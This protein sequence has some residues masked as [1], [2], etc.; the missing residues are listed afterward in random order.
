MQFNFRIPATQAVHVETGIKFQ[1]DYPVQE[2][3]VKLSIVEGQ[4]GEV[5]A[6]KA[7][8]LLGELRLEVDNELRR[9]EFSDLVMS[10]WKN[11]V[12]EVT[13]VL[14]KDKTRKVST[15]TVQSWL[16]DPSKSSSRTCPAWAVEALKNYLA[17]NPETGEIMERRLS[18]ALEHDDMMS[19]RAKRDAANESNR[20][21]ESELARKKLIQERLANCSISNLPRQLTEEIWALRE[22][23]ELQDMMIQA[24]ISTVKKSRNDDLEKNLDLFL[25]AGF[26]TNRATRQSME[27]IENGEL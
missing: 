5:T 11:D 25:R 8:A 15:R 12:L 9:R 6:D 26:E 7:N 21:A 19:V 20:W 10:G 16:A 1:I 2:G 24:L 22:K 23:L 17:A 13:S 27:E 18:L 3:E 14:S 4:D